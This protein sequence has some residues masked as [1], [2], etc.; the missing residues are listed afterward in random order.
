VNGAGLT[1][2]GRRYIYHWIK[3]LHS[4]QSGANSLN[5]IF[6]T[7][8]RL[9]AVKERFYSFIDLT[10]EKDM[11]FKL[12]NCFFGVMVFS[13]VVWSGVLPQAKAAKGTD[14]NASA[15]ANTTRDKNI[16][17]TVNGTAITQEQFDNAENYQLEV[18]QLKNVTLTGAQL[19]ELK[20]QILQGLI[21]DELLYQES[22]RNGIVVEEKEINDAYEARKQNA[23]FK[24]DAEFEE[25]LKKSNK[26]MAAY[27]A[28][29][30]H[31]LAVDQFIKNKFTDKT[32]IPD[33]DAKQYYDSNPGYF[34]QPARVRVS[35]I[36]I[37]VAPDADQSQKDEATQKL[38]QA[39]KRL[40][41]G[42]DFAAVAKEVSEDTKTKD[43]GGDL[44]YIS[45]GLVQKSFDD[46]AFSLEKDQISGIVHT[47]AG[48]HILKVT[49]K[50]DPK[51]IS[52]DEAKDNIIKSLR[53]SVVQ[54]SVNSYLKE[55]RNRSTIVTYPIS[56]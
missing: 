20:Y 1:V 56:L 51:T 11:Q 8:G 36:M 30:G 46:A 52:F 5:R 28:E 33:S 13:L 26:T 3:V 22:K 29:I 55:L 48:Y 32:V 44:G 39:L 53:S 6:N 4:G 15:P 9:T 25:A 47:S 42:E 18:A 14:K 43:N 49:D 31:G 45:K 2:C 16:V 19:S 21:D 34:E 27:R 7:F 12:R 23:K 50:K 10:G 54:S 17:A 41:A 24:T 35:H 38:E 37:R 40:K